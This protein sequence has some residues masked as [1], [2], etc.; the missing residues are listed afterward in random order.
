MSIE[1]VIALALTDDHELQDRLWFDAPQP[2][3][4]EPHQLRAAITNEEV[5]VR[6]NP[7][8]GFVTLAAYDAAGGFVRRDLFSDDEN[9]GYIADA[10]LLQQLA[11]DRLIEVAQTISGEGWKW[12]ETRVKRD[13]RE[14]PDIDV[15][16]EHQRREEVIQYIYRKYGRDRAAIAA[17]VS[18]YRPR[19]ALR[20]TGKALVS[21]RRSSTR[22]QRATSG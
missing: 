5:E 3:L 2:W 14:P 9:A 6:N 17:A 21:I 8:V 16:F 22:S 4:R 20:E 10:A 11:T 19:G 12:V 18:T 1:Q 13:Y 7:L 15:D